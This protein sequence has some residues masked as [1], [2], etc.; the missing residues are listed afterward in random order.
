MKAVFFILLMLLGVV[1]GWAQE[2]EHFQVFDVPNSANKE[3]GTRMVLVDFEAGTELRVLRGEEVIFSRG[4]L[5]WGKARYL[6]ED[7]EFGAKCFW[8]PTGPLVAFFERQTKRSGD[9]TAMAIKGGKVQEM[10]LKFVSEAAKAKLGKKARA[11]FTRPELWL[12]NDRLALSVGGTAE[13][14][15]YQFVA[16]VEFKEVDGVWEAKLESLKP[17]EGVK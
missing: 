14:D 12:P 1:T 16:I 2:V 13:G 9:T 10:D 15:L 11:I 4:A 3:S 8:A 5:G 17:S 7:Q 6:V